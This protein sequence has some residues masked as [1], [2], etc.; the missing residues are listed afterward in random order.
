MG[1]GLIPSHR[2]FNLDKSQG[3]YDYNNKCMNLSIIML[4]YCAEDYDAALEHMNKS[5]AAEN[6][7]LHDDN[8]QLNSLIKEFEQTLESVMSSF[9]K[10]AVC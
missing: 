1:E 9:R 4:G 6:E 7:D 10:H 5:L 3:K 2:R 8:K